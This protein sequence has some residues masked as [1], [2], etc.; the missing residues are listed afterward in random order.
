MSQ[1]KT[2]SINA[3]DIST[4]METV[5]GS[6]HMGPDRTTVADVDALAV[7]LKGY[8]LPATVVD[9]GAEWVKRDLNSLGTDPLLSLISALGGGE[10]Q[11]DAERY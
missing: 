11:R 4:F 5:F 3:R 7:Q 8:G 6:N 10:Q 2:F 1:T 9:G